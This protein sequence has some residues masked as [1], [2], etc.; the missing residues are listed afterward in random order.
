MNDTPRR[1]P[2][3]VLQGFVSTPNG[4]T[5][6][7]K[8]DTYEPIKSDDLLQRIQAAICADEPTDGPVF[9]ECGIAREGTVWR[10]RVT[11]SDV[12]SPPVTDWY[13]AWAQYAPAVLEAVSKEEL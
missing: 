12:W 5:A 8:I 2:K 1:Y 3:V 11:P 6:N 9:V 10:W 7:V 4:A 13:T